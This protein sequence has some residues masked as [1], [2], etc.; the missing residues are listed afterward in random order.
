M[1]K[2]K[3]VRLIISIGVLASFVALLFSAGCAAPAPGTAPTQTVTVTATPAAPEK[4]VWEIRLQ[5]YMAPASV[6]TRT[7][8][9][10]FVPRM[11]EATDGRIKVTIFDA[12]T[13]VETVDIIDALGEGMIDMA[14]TGSGYYLGLLGP[15]AGF[16]D[17]NPFTFHSQSEWQ[18]LFYDL[19]L[20]E[21]AR[22]MY[23]PHNV[24]LIGEIL[25]TGGVQAMT[26]PPVSRLSDF[27]GLKLRAYGTTAKLLDKMGAATVFLPGG[28]I[29]TAAATG[30]IDGFCFSSPST[31]FNY[32]LHEVAKY[33]I[34]PSLNW[35]SNDVL[36]RPDLWAE[37]PD[38]LKAI[39]EAVVF[40]QA[41]LCGRQIL[42]E[43][44]EAEVNMADY[45]ITL[46]NLP[47][48]DVLEISRLAAELWEEEAA[49]D[50]A[51]QKAMD[52]IRD[53]QKF[54]G[55]IK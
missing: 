16:C 32:G 43:D 44:R 11:E 30:V 5:A 25:S 9:A 6:H 46:V 19:G 35:Y 37:F 2:N 40:E 7:L 24:Y 13:L 34:K 51:A 49:G 12:G 38:D 33:R 31:D 22:E 1:L 14:H 53:Y 52:I 54:L 8:K 10:F 18:T 29:Y 27:E 4:K 26:T 17:P 48:E 42:Y 3:K 28:E 15:V 55:R 21:V 20:L 41:N 45:G 50:P 36:I 39:M 47:E 23:R